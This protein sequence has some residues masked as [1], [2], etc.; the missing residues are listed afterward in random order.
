MDKFVKSQDVLNRLTSRVHAQ[1]ATIDELTRQLACHRRFCD[2][3]LAKNCDRIEPYY[4]REN[5]IMEFALGAIALQTVL[6]ERQT[7]SRHALLALLKE[8]T[9]IVA[10]AAWR[11]DT[12]CANDA[13]IQ[14][15]GTIIDAIVGQPTA[16]DSSHQSMP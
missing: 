3:R 12:D 5:I 11:F 2:E 9:D 6:N 8:V 16:T 10:D 4:V 14:P 1:I 15:Y 13:W 7:A